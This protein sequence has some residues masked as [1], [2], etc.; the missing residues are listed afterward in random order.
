M[1]RY[2]NDEPGKTVKPK[3]K[4]AVAITELREVVEAKTGSKRGRPPKSDKAEP[5]VAE[6]ISRRTWY[7][8]RKEN[9]A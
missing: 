5:W 3:S 9:K 6:G 8:R 4:M 1:I 7:N 2:A